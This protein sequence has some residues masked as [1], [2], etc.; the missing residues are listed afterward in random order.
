MIIFYKLYC[1]KTIGYVYLLIWISLV[2]VIC[3]VM[4]VLFG[5]NLAVFGSG[6]MVFFINQTDG[7]GCGKAG[8]MAGQI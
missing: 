7:D 8:E 6:V 1:L 4:D 5:I 3:N 2:G